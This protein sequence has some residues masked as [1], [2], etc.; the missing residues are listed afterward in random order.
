MSFVDSLMEWYEHNARD[1]PWRS[2]PSPYRT[3]ISEVMLQQTQVETVIP[4]FERWMNRFPD[5]E[6]LV[7]STEQEVLTLWEGL[8]YYRRARNLHRAAKM[9][10]TDYAGQVPDAPTHLQKLAGIGPYTAAAIAAI[11][12]KKDISAVDGNIRRV[13]SRLFNIEEPVRSNAGEKIICKLAEAHLPKG[14]ASSYNQALMDLGATICTP[15]AP[16]CENCPIKTHC[17]AFASGLQKER[18]VKL[19]RKKVPHHTV[20]AAVIIKKDR[21]LLTQRPKNGLLGGLWE[22]PG[23]TLE[24]DDDDL[25]ACLRR[26]IR[27]ECGIDIRIADSFGKYKHAYT[28]FKITLHAFICGLVDG[29]EP[30]PLECDAVHWAGVDQLE[31][32][33]MGKVD[34]RIANR[35]REEGLNGRGSD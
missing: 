20:T 30:E 11:A 4:Y 12:F 35:L 8:G 24:K 29:R 5:I 15:K 6:T 33:P 19:P 34:R 27:E 32:F 23:G 2:H 18:P 14:K 3:W 28:H 7:A 25:E 31:Q 21:V 10:M 17:L 16:D 26:E 22:F 13:F 9:I 1:L